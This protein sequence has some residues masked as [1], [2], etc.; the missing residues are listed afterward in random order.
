[1]VKIAVIGAGMRGLEYMSFIKYMHAR[2]EN[3]RAV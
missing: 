3:R 2:R 1:M